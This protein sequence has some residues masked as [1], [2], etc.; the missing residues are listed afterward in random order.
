MNKELF[1]KIVIGVR[2][3]DDYYLCKKKNAPDF[4][5]HLS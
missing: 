2:E 1:A 5:G 4:L 3:Y